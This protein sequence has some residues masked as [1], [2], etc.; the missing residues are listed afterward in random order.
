M[1]VHLCL[2]VCVRMFE[3]QSTIQQILWVVNQLGNRHI[4]VLG[5][6]WSNVLCHFTSHC[7]ILNHSNSYH[8]C[9]WRHHMFHVDIDKAAEQERSAH[10]PVQSGECSL[11]RCECCCPPLLSNGYTSF[12]WQFHSRGSSYWASPCKLLWR[13]KRVS[14][15][16]LDSINYRLF[17]GGFEKLKARGQ[18]LSILDNDFLEDSEGFFHIIISFSFS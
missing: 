11:F 5:W 3:Q 14:A 1:S 16:A 8:I 13:V 4:S 10:E 7:T 2:C 17:S 15:E 18:L 6:S 9:A 12:H